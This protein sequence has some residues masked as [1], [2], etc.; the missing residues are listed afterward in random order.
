MIISWHISCLIPPAAIRR[1]EKAMKSKKASFGL[2]GMA[3]GLLWLS[4]PAADAAL[5]CI[6]DTANNI[7]TVDTVTG[8]VTLKGNANIGAT[9][10]DIGFDG[11]GNLYGTSFTN[12]YSINKNTGAAT[13][14]SALGAGGGG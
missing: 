10:T 12:F 7:G 4:A 2:S 11:N 8:T 13:F 14:I 6:D 5:L 9:L 1:G 3:L